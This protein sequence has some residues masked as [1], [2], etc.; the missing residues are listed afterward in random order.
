MIGIGLTDTVVAA[1]EQ[2][3]VHA[4]VMFSPRSRSC[5]ASTPTFG[6]VILNNARMLQASD[7]QLLRRVY[8]PSASAWIFS[9]LH[10]S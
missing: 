8:L 2:G 7:R 9:S 6:P 3:Q 10:T 5:R 4:A 1:M